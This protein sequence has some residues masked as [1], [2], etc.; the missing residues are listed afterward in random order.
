MLS[1]ACLQ[2]ALFVQAVFLFHAGVNARATTVSHSGRH[3]RSRFDLR[4]EGDPCA[5][6]L[7]DD[8][9]KLHPVSLIR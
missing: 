7:N 6:V 9:R 8:D 3:E 2:L 1:L 4:A 5:I